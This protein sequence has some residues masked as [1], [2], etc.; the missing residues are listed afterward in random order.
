VAGALVMA[1]TVAARPGR[2]AARAPTAAGTAFGIAA[3]V[4]SAG[5]P[6]CN[7]WWGLVRTAKM[8]CWT[9]V[10]TATV[11]AALLWAGPPAPAGIGTGAGT[12]AATSGVWSAAA[13]A[14]TGLRFTEKWSTRALPDA[15]SPIAESSPIVA[16]LDDEGPAVVVGDR[17]GYLYAFHLAD[18]SKIAGWPVWDGGPAIDS[19]PSVAA[20]GGGT[21]LDSVFV[22]EGNARNAKRGGGYEAFA[23]NGT[24]QWQVV[25]ANPRSDKNPTSAVQAS[26]TVAGLQGGS[27]VFAGSLG[28]ESYGLDATDGTL[29]HGFP[30]FSA[31]SVFS[32]AAAGDLYGTGQTE[33]VVG[34]A[35]SAG[36][37]F[38]QEY[39]AGGHVRVL[40]SHG[41]LIC[42]YDTDQE[43][44]SSPAVGEFLPSGA[45]GIAV[46]TGDFYP[47]ADSTDVL[48][49]FNTNCALVWSAPLDGVTSSSPALAD[50]LGNG[51]LDV[52]EGTHSGRTGSVWLLDGSSGTVI[53]H[54]QVV[55]PVVG[56]V[57]TAD[58]SGQGYQDIVVPTTHG[59]EVLDGRTGYELK[60][61]A[62]TLGFQNS[63][64][65]TDDPDGRVGVTVAGYNGK[66]AGVVV[67]Y[68][69]PGSDGAVA[70]AGGSWPM[71]HH[72]PQLSGVTG[73]LPA[74]GSIPACQVP[75]AAVGGYHLVSADGGV[76]SFGQPF[77][78]T[79]TAGG[80]T[81]PIVGIAMAPALGGYW[82]AAAD[83]AVA[84]FGQAKVYGSLAG[85][86]LPSPIVGIAAT[87]DGGGYWLA[88]SDGTVYAYGDAHYYGDLGG[89]ALNAPVVGIATTPDGLGY[90][91]A[92]A[93]GGVFCFG[94]GRFR[95]S[96]TGA[97]L[98]APV[99]GITADLAQG[100]YS[101]VAADGGVFSFGTPFTGST[102]HMRLN[103]P[104]VGMAATADAR[105]YW[106]AAADGGVFGFGD[107]PFAGSMGSHRLSAPVTGVAGYAA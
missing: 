78:G 107:A 18:G 68:E 66:N 84:A 17:A 47:G 50:V 77:C 53:W 69:I 58:L 105:G 80:L 63:P 92:A 56:S 16:N 8:R 43:V 11:T 51:R 49:A 28:Q 70:V 106:V 4:P 103:G 1:N 45:V 48:D 15:G 64:L 90:R 97:R 57:V 72:D 60:I 79:A 54:T 2:E 83:G 3:A 95:G 85:A 38:G 10:P 55:A 75:S 25:A 62:P 34:G 39:R 26:M 23:A 41:G 76:F 13:P 102:G 7:L 65:V 6:R 35:S 73:P 59:V 87:P 81:P 14:G 29:L 12:N 98:S 96:L 33:L 21:D 82:L 93:D 52:V 9:A 20:L 91:L 104:V 100:G 86:T 30:F 37:A 24:A 89:H 67:H 46:G 27:D 31:D 94:D 19:T 71:F 61:L 88:S 101:L 5:P 32:T 42:R 40:N 36:L 99:V 74:R 44:D 22:G